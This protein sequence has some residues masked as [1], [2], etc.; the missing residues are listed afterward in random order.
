V[1]DFIEL[2]CFD[3]HREW[4]AHVNPARIGSI[5]DMPAGTGFLIVDGHRL[6]CHETSGQIKQLIA[7]A[8]ER[9]ALAMARRP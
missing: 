9:D 4:I 7:E 5:E 6:L 2:H 1:T 8:K 3:A